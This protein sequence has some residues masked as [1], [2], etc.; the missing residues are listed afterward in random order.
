MFKN[1]IY[2]IYVRPLRTRIY[3]RIKYYVCKNKIYMPHARKYY[4]NTRI[5]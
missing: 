3:T 2:F 1:K 5:F 4:I